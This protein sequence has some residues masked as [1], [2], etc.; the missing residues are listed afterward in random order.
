MRPSTVTR[1]EVFVPSTRSQKVIPKDQ[2]KTVEVEGS[3]LEELLEDAPIYRL[4]YL[5][6]QQVSYLAHAYIDSILTISREQQ[7]F[8]WPAYLI[9]N[10]S[11]QS[12]YPAW[13]NRT[14]RSALST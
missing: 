10:A 7:L 12:F 5:L 3:A 1:E 14:F 11:G 8:G 2:R 6:V 13:T 9:M 4:Y